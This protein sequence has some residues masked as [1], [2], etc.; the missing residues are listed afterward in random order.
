MKYLVALFFLMP[1]G[2]VIGQ[3]A[4]IKGDEVLFQ[5]AVLIQELV[6]GELDLDY[7]LNDKNAD[8]SARTLAEHTKN[9][10]L[11]KS[12]DL[13]YELVEDYP[14]S[15]WLF[16]A[17][18]NIGY[19]ELAMQ[20]YDRAKEVF[21]RII[22]GDTNNKNKNKKGANLDGANFK[23]R[24]AKELVKIGIEEGNFQEALTYLKLSEQFP[25]QHFCGNAFA[26]ED[27]YVS[28]LYAKCYMGLN[29]PDK[30][31]EVLLPNL[32]ENRLADNSA[33]VHMVF[34]ILCASYEVDVLRELYKE[35]F[36]NVKVKTKG[37]KGSEYE[38]DYIS[39][40][41]VDIDLL[42]SFS[43]Y[44]SDRNDREQEINQIYIDSLFYKLLN[45]E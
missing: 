21:Q 14:N 7:Y 5:K 32:L 39:F 40:L 41:A 12:V 29:Q 8:T 4:P 6:E 11:N 3:N 13:Y 19:A 38:V 34:D 37:V 18:N 25:Y 45:Q 30:A 17:L 2:Q 1:L 36:K 33:A 10:M 22:M 28:L 31:I 44:S 16:Y 9:A 15:P 27:I 20:Q 23:N 26:E 43:L 42:Y 24:A 35:S